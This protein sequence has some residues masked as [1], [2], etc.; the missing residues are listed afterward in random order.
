MSVTTA[1]MRH[2]TAANLAD[3]TGRKQASSQEAFERI[4][5]T[6]M[7]LRGT[8][9]CLVAKRQRDDSDCSP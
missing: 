4:A 3:V 6:L 5:R 2:I 9:A 7:P 1:G 8:P